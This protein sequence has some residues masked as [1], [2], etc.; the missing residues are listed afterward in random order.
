M[1]PLCKAMAIVQFQSQR[2]KGALS[3]FLVNYRDTP[4]STTGVSP[5]QIIFTGDG[6]R[7]NL[8]D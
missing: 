5:V 7:I 8:P 4:H 6:Y 3:S 1:K 2:E